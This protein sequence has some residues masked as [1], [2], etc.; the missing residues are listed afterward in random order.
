MAKE[1]KKFDDWSGGG[2]FAGGSF[3]ANG[4]YRSLNLQRYQNGSIGPR[5][6][7][8]KLTNVGTGA[9]PNDVPQTLNPNVLS[10]G[11]GWHPYG[12]TTGYPNE[13]SNG[14]LW[15]YNLG[16]VSLARRIRIAPNGTASFFDGINAGYDSAAVDNVFTYYDA[17]K[18][19]AIQT[20]YENAEQTYIGG[21]RVFQ[22]NVPSSTPI[23]ARVINGQ[24]FRPTKV[25][26]YR[27]RMYG[28]DPIGTPAGLLDYIVVSESASLIDYSSNNSDAFRL[29]GTAGPGGAIGARPR[30][31]WALQSGLLIFSTGGSTTSDSGYGSTLGSSTSDV[32]RWFMLTGASPATGSLTPLDQD[33]GPAFFSLAIQYEG[34]VLFPS[35]R[36]GWS[37]HDGQVVDKGSLA[38]LRPGGGHTIPNFTW[39]NPIKTA[40]KA[41]LMLPFTVDSD[42]DVSVDAEFYRTGYGG[43]EFVNG[44]WTEHRYNGG[45]GN[46]VGHVSITHDKFV[47]VQLE[48][49]P[50]SSYFVPVIYVRDTTLDR[51]TTI[52]P[53]TME[54]YNPYSSHIETGLHKGG[55][56]VSAV[57][58]MFLETGEEAAPDG[59]YIQVEAVSVLYDYWNSS[60]FDQDC[61]FEIEVIY[62]GIDY[63]GKLTV[64]VTNQRVT[65]PAV[66]YGIMPNRAQAFFN[67]PAYISASTYQIRIKDIIGV[68]IN[69][70]KV[71][72]TTE[73][74][75]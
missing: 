29:S 35:Y 52:E 21:T 5:P 38:E 20:A 41:S 61:G 49:A 47:S 9:A 2:F 34:K 64:P 72:Y 62:R 24:L 31:M 37:I 30:G 7:W 66:S 33:I 45:E 46:M 17:Y 54:L 14:V 56:A 53:S 15:L 28:W 3:K 6:G 48:P 13:W 12:P 63:S 10:V 43:F 26:F 32:G 69:S 23:T 40:R 74:I 59:E 51:P 36:R 67:L 11:A 70:I 19:N 60:L 4:R 58:E 75:R 42:P 18:I 16:N 57:P 71:A 73:D 8:R 25:V 39:F 27:G 65:P 50:Y 55:G 44:A 1:W 68:A 22:P